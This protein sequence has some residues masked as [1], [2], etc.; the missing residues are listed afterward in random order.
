MNKKHESF[1]TGNQVIDRTCDK[2]LDA[3]RGA[4]VAVNVVLSLE[5]GASLSEAVRTAAK[6]HGYPLKTLRAV[7][8]R[9]YADTL[10]EQRTYRKEREQERLM[11]FRTLEDEVLY[12]TQEAWDVYEDIPFGADDLSPALMRRLAELM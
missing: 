9:A 7:G 11:S 2:I 12:D 6:A 8:R 1:H 10:A 5:M 4:P 3:L